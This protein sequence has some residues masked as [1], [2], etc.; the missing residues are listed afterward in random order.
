M[1]TPIRTGPWTPT[2]VA[3]WRRRAAEAFPDDPRAQRRL[4]AMQARAAELRDLEFRA[5]YE[6]DR[7]E[8]VRAIE[9][10]ADR[11]ERDIDAAAVQSER[12]QACGPDIPARHA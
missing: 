7:A 6:K 12:G 1:T 3:E 5:E 11:I 10:K 9:R 2:D 8:A 4:V